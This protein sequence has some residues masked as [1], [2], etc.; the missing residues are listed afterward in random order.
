MEE[1][2]KQFAILL[3][4]LLGSCSSTPPAPSNITLSELGEYYWDNDSLTSNISLEKKNFEL[5]K[6]KA[7]CKVQKLSVQIPAPSCVQPPR[8]DCSGLQGFALGFCRSYRPQPSCDYSA[9]N[10]AKEA[11]EEI[12]S[13]CMTAEGWTLSFSSEGFGSDTSGGLYSPA[14]ANNGTNQWYVKLDS[15]KTSDRGASALV[16]SE[17]VPGIQCKRSQYLWIIDYENRT[18]A[19]EQEEPITYIETDAAS[20]IAGF[21]KNHSL[22]LASP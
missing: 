7:S 21:L 14:I 17:C 2:T 11:Q 20:F 1:K 16:R 22:K 3:L 5:T 8:R 15:I 10:A 13:A 19:V 4:V 6:A 9:V 12:W 18:V